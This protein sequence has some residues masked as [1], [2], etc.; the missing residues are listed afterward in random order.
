[1]R[2]GIQNV[3]SLLIISSFIF[4]CAAPGST[5]RSDSGTFR[6]RW[7]NYYNRGLTYSAEGDWDNALHDLRKAAE[8]RDMDQRMARIR[9]A[10]SAAIQGDPPGQRTHPDRGMAGNRP[11]SGAGGSVRIDRFR[12]VGARS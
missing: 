12:S 2:N 1:M 5:L 4:S 10:D 11:R 3:L 9:R 7:Y 8:K 6:G